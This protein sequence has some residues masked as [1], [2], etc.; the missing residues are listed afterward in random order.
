MVWDSLFSH[1]DIF[2]YLIS[3]IDINEYDK[4]KKVSTRFNNIFN[5]RYLIYNKIYDK[6]ICIN[7]CTQNNILTIMEQ[8]ILSKYN[9]KK[10]SRIVENILK[11]G[12]VN[13][14]NISIRSRIPTMIEYLID[15]IYN[16]SHKKHR[17][18]LKTLNN[19]YGNSSGN[20]STSNSMFLKDKDYTDVVLSIQICFNLYDY[21]DNYSFKMA[22]LYRL[23]IGMYIFILIKILSN[24]FE[25]NYNKLITNKCENSLRRLFKIQNKKL[26]EHKEFIDN[27]LYNKLFPKYYKNSIMSLTDKLFIYIDN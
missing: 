23:N 24:S 25:L 6:L 7:G 5:L 10:N 20:S 15:L 11:N 12:N 4:L 9:F 3:I 27:P 26:D 21:F 13:I 19:I 1:N 18:I 2:E 16:I 8:C 14:I 17:N 22:I